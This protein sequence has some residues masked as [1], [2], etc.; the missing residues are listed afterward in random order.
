MKISSKLSESRAKGI[1][2]TTTE[3]SIHIYNIIRSIFKPDQI[4]EPFAGEGSL[5]KPF[6][7]NEIPIIINDIKPIPY[8]DE[9]NS[10]N[11]RIFNKDF[12]TIDKQKII[13]DWIRKSTENLL[14]YSNPPFGTSS[15]NK[16]SSKIKELNKDQSRTININY[17]GLGAIYGKGDI[18]LPALGKMIEV[19]VQNK[20][21]YL[22]FFSPL[23]VFCGR[24]R[25]NK[26]LS[27]I[28]VNFEFLYGEI[29]SGDHFENVQNTKPISFT[30]WKYKKDFNT[31]HSS[32]L[33]LYNGKQIKLEIK[34]L[35]K[36][37]W[38]YDNRK[39]IEGEIV[40]Q[41][42]DRFNVQAPKMLHLKIKKGGSELISKNVKKS[43]NH[44]NLPDELIIGLWSLAVGHRSLTKH[45]L[46][47]DNA[48]VHLPDFSNIKYERLLGYIAV[49]SI[50]YE[51][52]H[53]YCEGKININIKDK[54]INFGGKNLTKGINYLLT[55]Y[56][57]EFIG[58]TSI[59]SIIYS[60][61]TKSF[62]ELPVKNYLTEIKVILS[63][64]LSELD[65]WGSI[66]IPKI[67]S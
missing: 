57:H 7:N 34:P 28:L 33:F 46:Y 32:L 54:K 21:G 50:L 35:L 66:P 39:Y 24:K 2:Y 47:I 38:K 9:F 31:P 49:Y 53:D 3:L 43:L 37:Y 48:Y 59:K 42:N 45:P 10:K 20:N 19:I 12:I 62:L 36:D 61:H 29:F 41:G 67:S 64:Q 15:T 44:P 40:V 22:G 30:L 11:I 27:K 65:Y 55:K 16:L 4:I 5:V 14:L 1:Y 56:N 58:S 18:L 23:G 60:L 8:T 51:L 52:K 25:F 26:L 63:N 13:N 6:L 17:G